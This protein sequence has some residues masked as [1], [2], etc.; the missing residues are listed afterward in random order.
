RN[1]LD[2]AGR[3]AAVLPCADCEGIDTVVTLHMDGTFSRQS[4]YLGKSDRVFSDTGSFGWDASGSAVTLVTKQGTAQA[5]KVGEN[6]LIHL[7]Q[8]GRPITGALAA[9]YVLLKTR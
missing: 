4:R 9:H 5:Y 8:S 1:S 6:R 2:W 7:D 3:Y